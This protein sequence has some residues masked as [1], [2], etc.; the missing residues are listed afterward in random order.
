MKTSNGRK[1]SHAALSLTVLGALLG[2]A[3]DS[4]ALGTPGACQDNH[5]PVALAPGL[6]ADQE[7]FARLC[8]PPG[9]TPAT[10]QL[11]IHGIT[12]SHLHWDFPDPTGHTQRYSYVSA[13]LDAGFA[14]L[15][16]DRIGSGKSSHPPGATVSIDSNA[17]V[18]HQVVQALRAGQVAGPSGA[19]GFQKVVLVGH[20]YGSFT[21]WYEASDYQDVDGVILSGVSHTIQLTSPLRVLVPLYPAALDPAFFGQG[22]DLTYMTTQPGTRYGAFYAPG[23]ADPAVVALDERTKGTVT[24]TEFA[25]FAVVLARPLDIR[26]PVLLVNGA[27]DRLFCGPT[28]SGTVCSSAEALIS[29]EKPRLGAQVPCV[30]AFVLPGAGHDLNTILDAQQWFAVAQSWMTRRIGAGADQTPGCG[31]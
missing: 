28:L 18:V 15:A 9:Q 5:I 20:S 6:P 22:Y 17:Y 2:A 30:E 25:P 14:T 1:L 23:Q 26:V 7:V 27:E 29:A 4:H 3:P 10:V 24:D 21:S 16:M 12:Y 19:V 13:A 11:L 31:P 8:L